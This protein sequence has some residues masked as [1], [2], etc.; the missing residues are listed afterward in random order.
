MLRRRKKE[1]KAKFKEATSEEKV[2]Y[3]RRKHLINEHIENH[4]KEENRRRT[5]RLANKI[6]SEKGFDGS[7]FWEFKRRSSGKRKEEMTAI[8]NEEGELEENPEKIL[9]IYQRFYEKLL[10]GKK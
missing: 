1:I 10:T 6:K 3:R 4:Q 9:E 2:I 7:A 8:K 5:I